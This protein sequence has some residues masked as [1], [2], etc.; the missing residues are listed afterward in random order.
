MAGGASGGVAG[1]IAG[2]AAGGS[3]AG[4]AA[5]GG[6]GG[7]T[8][9]PEY[10]LCC[11]SSLVTTCECPITGCLNAPF[12]PCPGNRC[13]AGTSAGERSNLG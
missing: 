11:V 3:I 2:G 9:E 13:V 1:G 6:T 12:T 7:G 5:G 10:E 8:P 4:G